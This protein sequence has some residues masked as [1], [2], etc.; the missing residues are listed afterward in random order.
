ML[1]DVIVLE[2]SIFFCDIWLCNLW[3]ICNSLWCHTNPKSKDKKLN[4]KENKNKNKN[5]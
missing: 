5:K 2:P 1:Y 4:G 3:Q